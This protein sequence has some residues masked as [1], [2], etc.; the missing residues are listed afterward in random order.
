MK[1]FL[2]EEEISLIRSIFQEPTLVVDLRSEWGA[3]TEGYRDKI[4]TELSARVCVCSDSS[5]SHC[6][7]LGGFAFVGATSVQV[8]LDVEDS[9]RVTPVI[10]RRITKT[11]SEFDSAPAPDYLWAAKE[12]AF[13]SLKGPTQP[14]VISEVEIGNWKEVEPGVWRFGLVGKEFFR[15]LV[16]RKNEFVIAVGVLSHS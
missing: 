14:K 16:F 5:I 12:A 7:K 13:K 2:S 11:Q 15:G 6:E 4:K 3:S 8:G 9:D 10:V 1:S